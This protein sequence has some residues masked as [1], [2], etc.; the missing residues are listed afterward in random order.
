MNTASR[1]RRYTYVVAVTGL[2]LLVAG[3]G[4]NDAA[5][6]ASDE[7]APDTDVRTAPDPDEPDCS[8][9]GH[10]VTV[11]PAGDLPDEVVAQRDLLIDA[12]LRCDEQLLNTAI[13]ESEQFTFSFGD[14]SDPIGYWWDLEAAGQA[15]FLRLAQVLATTPAI[16]D[17]GELAVFPRVAT[18]RAQDTTDEAWAELHWVEDL[19]AVT[20][21]GEGY[22]GW[23]VGIALDG[24][25]QFFVAGD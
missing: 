5:A 24:Q 1:R 22:L 6:A 20:G 23:R 7:T 18:G 10:S 21:G 13:E 9:H 15:P 16:D 17:S 2:A 19:D 11:L 12:A 8:A 14:D 4:T 25:W 3:C